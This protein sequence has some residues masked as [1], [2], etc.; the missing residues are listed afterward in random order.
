MNSLERKRISADDLLIERHSFL[1][2]R[3]ET[4]AFQLC[5]VAEG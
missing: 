4:A 2:I 5:P 3:V 1:S